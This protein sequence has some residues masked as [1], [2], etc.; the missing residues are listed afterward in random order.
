MPEKFGHLTRRVFVYFILC[1]IVCN[2]NSTK[3]LTVVHNPSNNYIHVQVL[4][5]T[6]KL[7]NLMGDDWPI[8]AI[9]DDDQ[10]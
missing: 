10:I 6:V 4:R 3:L 9:T 8:I 5:Y 2:N 7:F 1:V